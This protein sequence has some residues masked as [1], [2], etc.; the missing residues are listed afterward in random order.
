[1]VESK[2][3]GSYYKY[4]NIF[5]KITVNTL[6]F[7]YPGVDHAIKIIKNIKRKEKKIS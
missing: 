3:P 6:L 7:Y 4:L 1:E 2:L 5:S